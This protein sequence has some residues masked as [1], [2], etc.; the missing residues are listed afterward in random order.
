MGGAAWLSI[1]GL[2][3][4]P[5]Y[6]ITRENLEVITMNLIR[7]WSA[8]VSAFVTLAMLTSCAETQEGRKT[9]AQGTGLGALLGAAVGAGL[10]AAAGGGRGA[11]IGAAS[12]AAVGGAAGFAYGT[13]VAH[14][15]AKYAKAED[16]LNACI[17]SAR[18]ERRR[19]Y[20]VN[21]KVS[22]RLANLQ[23]RSKAA[24]AS[25]DKAAVTQI[26]TEIA[27]LK[28]EANAEVKNVNNEVAAQQN[29]LKDSSARGSS[30]YG[31]L[32]E[33]VGSLEA[34]KAQL[35]QNISRLAALENQTNL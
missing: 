29:A 35:G 20:A 9:Q 18:A 7:R 32:K 26:R 2:G 34:S 22:T 17:A 3:K 6:V 19:A 27:T 12:G 11:A 16:W 10:G 31:Q 33:S 1:F 23:R 8:F 14:Q 28:Q 30:N 15:K 24:V 4:A 5:F 25:R 21:E 13:H